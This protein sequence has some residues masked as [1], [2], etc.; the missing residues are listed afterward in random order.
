MN[1]MTVTE[2]LEKESLDGY[3]F[4]QCLR[5]MERQLPVDSWFYKA[6]SNNPT[7]QYV[8]DVA[9]LMGE[10][11][12]LV[13]GVCKELLHTD[14]PDMYYKYVMGEDYEGEEEENWV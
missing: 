8:R 9:S 13:E 3:T 5:E 4:Y 10:D 11:C 1:T 14:L 12:T 6:L 7:Y 2:Y